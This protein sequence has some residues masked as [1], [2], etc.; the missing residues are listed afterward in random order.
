MFIDFAA[1]QCFGAP[2]E[3]N[4]QVDEYVEL[5][6][7][8]PPERRPYRCRSSINI[9]SLRDWAILSLVELLAPMVSGYDAPRDLTLLR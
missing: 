4:V 1:N 5:I 3:R 8:V 7:F 2:A 6:H 9:R